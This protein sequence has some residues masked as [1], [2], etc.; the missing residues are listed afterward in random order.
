MPPF[1]RSLIKLITVRP[2]PF[3]LLGFLPS[4]TFLFYPRS[5]PSISFMAVM[6]AWRASWA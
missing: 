2:L 1:H 4:R 5:F 3:Q 6:N